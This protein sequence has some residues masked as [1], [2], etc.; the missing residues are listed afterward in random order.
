MCTH[1][2]APGVVTLVHA[3]D[4]VGEVA[5]R[6]EAVGALLQGAEGYVL[7]V[8]DPA[9]QQRVVCLT[10]G[11]PMPSPELVARLGQQE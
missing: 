8:G 2:V 5:Q 1:L 6:V 10:R 9:R 3:D 11:N 7:V 4:T